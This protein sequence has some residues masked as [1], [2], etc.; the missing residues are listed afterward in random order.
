[1]NNTI[2]RRKPDTVIVFKANNQKKRD[3]KMALYL[4]MAP[5]TLGCSS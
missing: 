3:I 1:M 4:T 2:V 5:S